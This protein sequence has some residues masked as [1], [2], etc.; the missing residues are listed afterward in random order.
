MRTL[1]LSL[2]LLAVS[3]STVAAALPA[4][5]AAGRWRGTVHVPAEDLSLVVD[6]EEDPAG[7]WRGSVTVPGLNLAGVAL[8]AI[9]VSGPRVAFSIP[10][11]LGAP[12]AGPAT[13]VAQL[14]PRSTLAGTFSVGGNSAPFVLTRAGPAQ[15][16][17]PAVSTAVAPALAGTWRGDY[18]LSGYAHHVTLAFTNHPGAAATVEFLLVGK[19]PHT[20]AVDLVA[21]NEGLLRVESHELSIN[22]EGRMDDAT[23]VLRGVVEQ[24]ALE[25]PI[26]L[27]RVTGVTP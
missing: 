13:F 6:L 24:G 1:L 23:G 22:F 21:E 26:E 14:K 7:G 2:A 18:Q 17:R 8:A 20:L 10:G 3:G 15:V 11:A 19:Q 5:S 16:E 27:R 4:E 9:S 12:P 25:A